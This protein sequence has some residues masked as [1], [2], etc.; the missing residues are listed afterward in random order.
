M[1][2]AIARGALQNFGRS[3]SALPNAF[4]TLKKKKKNYHFV[5]CYGSKKNFFESIPAKMSEGIF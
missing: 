4:G 5:D 2:A 1:V 3:G